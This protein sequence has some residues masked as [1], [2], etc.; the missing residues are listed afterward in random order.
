MQVLLE[1]LLAHLDLVGSHGNLQENIF[2][3]PAGLRVALRSIRL[4]G[5]VNLAPVTAPAAGIVSCA[6][7]AAAGALRAG[8]NHTGKRE[9]SEE[10]K[11]RQAQMAMRFALSTIR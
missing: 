5:R 11:Q 7:D 10:Q 1:S 4:I 8:R 2:S 6:A 9:G 3:A